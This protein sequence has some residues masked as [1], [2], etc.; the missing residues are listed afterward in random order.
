VQNWT[1]TELDSGERVISERLDHVR[2]AAVGY[3][4]GA[5]S[6][7]EQP[8]EA[9]V[10]HFIEHLL[11]K[12]TGRFSALEIAEIFDGLG[13]ELNA[14]T[15]R[16][17][18]LVYARIPDH[19][20]ETAM[21]VMSDMIFAPEFAELDSEREVVLE[22]IAMYDDAPQ[23]L[24]HDLIADAVFGDHPLG[25]PVIG[26]AEVIASIPKES[27]ARYHSQMYVPGNIVV[28]AA[29]NVEHERVVELVSRAL[30]RR[31]T[32]GAGQPN[33]RPPL[34][35]AAPP[36][37]RFQQKDTEQ[38]HVCLAA[39]GISRSDRRRFAAS[40]LDSILGGSAS[41]RLFQEIREKRGMAYAVYSFVSQ[42]TD[43]GQIGVY[44]GTREDNL[45]EALAI[46]A[47][48]ISDIAGGNLPAPEVER[49]KENLKGRILLSME[50]TSTRMNRLGKSLIADSELLSLDR[51]VAEIDAV[52]PA[53]VSA[54]A[55]SLLEPERLSAACIGP[56]EERFVSALE[57]IAPTLARAA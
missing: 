45:A 46:T 35:Q 7:D 17:H 10:T 33:V 13:G 47:E 28:A 21:D 6:R 26:T 38:Y 53:S 1:L 8:E 15:S 34:V 22:E 5:G 19:H 49:A 25:R 3:W 27:I 41:S 43:T 32:A 50:S 12:G 57:R 31:A 44:L 14:A 37:L 4:I 51:I 16:E 42:Y 36:R 2:S 39:P 54:L 23:E 29:G 18:T 52:E 48:Q 24:V 11:F 20:L 55:A 40:L 56:S 30:E 9:G